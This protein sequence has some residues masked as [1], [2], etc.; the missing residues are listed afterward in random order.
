MIVKAFIAVVG[1]TSS[2]SGIEGLS[3]SHRRAFLLDTMSRTAGIGSLL[4]YGPSI[5][6]AQENIAGGSPQ[7]GDDQ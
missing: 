1:F 5:A 3:Y 2:F 6:I 4:N 7:F